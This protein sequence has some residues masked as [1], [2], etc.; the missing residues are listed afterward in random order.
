[1]RRFL[2]M[3]LLAILGAISCTRE[4]V[5][6]NLITVNLFTG[7]LQTRSKTPG[8]G[9][10]A[11]GGG[12]FLD[13]GNPDLVI[14]LVSAGDVVVATYPDSEHNYSLLESGATSTSASVIFDFDAPSLA[15]GMYTVYAFAN[16]GGYWTMAG[17][18]GGQTAKDYLLSLTSGTA[19]ENLAFSPLT[20]NT[21]PSVINGRLPLSAK[22][23]VSVSNGTSDVTLELIRCVAKVTVEFINNTEED[24]TLTSFSNTFKKLCPDRGYV[25]RHTEDSPTGTVV[26]N[27]I[28]GEAS[29]SIDAWEDS[30]TQT[31]HGSKSQSWYVFPST[32]PYTC[33]VSFTYGTEDHSFTDLPVH[34]DHAVSIPSLGR[35]QHLH[36]VTRISKGKSVSF[37]FE[38]TQWNTP[39]EE[40]VQFE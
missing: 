30:T 37:N 36:I 38:V 29:L 31:Q 15:D 40:S 21:N 26:G 12:I 33:D 9:D 11:D 17:Q 7:D 25:I 20:E 28:K 4:E 32:G 16:T 2:I 6:R 13:S 23:T 35:N 14:L 1:M 18:G 24:L 34:D 8:D 10:P 19:V 39:I 22:G 27:L 5:T 3:S